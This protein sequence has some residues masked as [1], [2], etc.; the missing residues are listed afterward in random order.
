MTQVANLVW[1]ARTL[2]LRHLWKLQRARQ[3]GFAGINR[4]H[5]ES[6]VLGTLMNVG[7]FDEISKR[8]PLVVKEFAAAGGLDPIVLESLCAYLYE[9]KILRKDQKGYALE[10]LGELFAGVLSGLFDLTYAYEDLLHGLEPLLRGQATY[11]HD[12]HRDTHL[13]ARGTGNGGR[14]F[15]FPLAAKLIEENGF[16]HPLDVA[17][18]DAAFLIDVCQ[19][20]PS[21]VA[22]GL[23]IA[24]DVIEDG[25]KRVTEEGLDARIHLVVEDVFNVHRV[26]D[27]L[28]G[29]D[30]VTSFYGMQEFW[31]LGRD[32]LLA[33]IAEF[34][35]TFPGV[36]FLICEI[37]R[38]SP[39]ELRRRPGG[40][41]EYQLF[42]ALTGQHLAT[43]EEWNALWRD[44]GF[45]R[46]EEKYLAFAR[47]V[48]YILR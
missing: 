10:P 41:L 13:M 3:V 17:C 39:D 14:L 23:D 28:P 29:V 19:R 46:I 43:R 35:Q 7:F 6:R 42:H 33:L 11:G 31:S 22:Y 27:Q 36:A 8:P 15:T 16:H 24:T 20:N 45:T 21:I 26:V 38:Y 40:I 18:G 30:V 37:P 34:R 48:F 44:A 1:V 12:I 32:R 4:G 47:S 5:F 25:R 2:G 9:L